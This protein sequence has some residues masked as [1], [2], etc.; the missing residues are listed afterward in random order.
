MKNLFEKTNKFSLIVG[1][2]LITA[3]V[4]IVGLRFFSPEDSW[5][6]ENNEWVKHGNPAQPKPTTSCSDS[7]NKNMDDEGIFKD[8]AILAV[9]DSVIN[10]RDITKLDLSENQIETLPSQ[11]ENWVNLEEFNIQ[12]NKLI[13]LPAEI[14]HWQRL[15]MLDASGNRMTNVPAEIG[16]LSNLKEIDFSNNSI[17]EF[18]NELLNLTQLTKLDIRY[19][20]VSS[21]QIEKLKKALPKTEILH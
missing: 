6:C 2:L 5:V 20:P 13:S 8:Q 12:N 19:N 16:Q 10:N 7:S 11:V 18:P 4:I 21:D 14:R 9:P 1:G 17:T 15:K 3:V